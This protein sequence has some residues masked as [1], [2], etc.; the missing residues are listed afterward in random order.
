MSKNEGN[1]PSILPRSAPKTKADIESRMAK[2]KKS[3]MYGL[4]ETTG[5]GSDKI[6]SAVN[7]VYGGYE[8]VI[9][10]PLNIRYRAVQFLTLYWFF[11]VRK[12]NFSRG[13]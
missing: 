4:G 7:A 5:I 9:S 6:Q 11:T 10:L 1:W 3:L 8:Q 2:F 12:R 13:L